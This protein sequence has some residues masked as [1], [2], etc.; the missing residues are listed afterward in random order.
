MT[1]HP[2]MIRGGI[3]TD[4]WRVVLRAPTRKATAAHE[5]WHP[6]FRFAVEP[7]EDTPT[8][9]MALYFETV[10]EARAAVAGA[11]AKSVGLP[12]TGPGCEVLSLHRLIDGRWVEYAIAGFFGLVPAGQNPECCPWCGAGAIAP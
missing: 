11:W 7:E 1:A 10:D 4:L 12:T 8:E 2:D 6:V 5:A 9:D 3:G